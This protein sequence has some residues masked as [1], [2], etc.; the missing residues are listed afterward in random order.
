M[1][2]FF[3]KTKIM[4]SKIEKKKKKKSPSRH[5]YSYP[6]AGPETNFLLK[7]GLNSHFQNKK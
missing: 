3:A 7:G 4:K 2:E 6:A 1:T 5:K